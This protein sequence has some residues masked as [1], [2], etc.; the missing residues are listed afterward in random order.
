MRNNGGRTKEEIW[1]RKKG[2]TNKRD[3]EKKEREGKR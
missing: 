2:L 1:G 3:K